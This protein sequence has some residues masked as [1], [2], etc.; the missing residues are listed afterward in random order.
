VL[1]FPWPGHGPSMCPDTSGPHRDSIEAGQP[2]GRVSRQRVENVADAGFQGEAMPVSPFDE[3]LA[4]LLDRGAV[5]SLVLDYS[6]LSVLLHQVITSMVFQ[7]LMYSL[8]E[9]RHVAIPFIVVAIRAAVNEEPPFLK[10]RVS[11]I[12]TGRTHI[13]MPVPVVRE[14]GKLHGGGGGGVACVRFCRVADV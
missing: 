8:L 12:A 10:A 14:V 7:I 1:Q 3:A 4:N 5:Q 9:I 2:E 13:I 11:H 6:P